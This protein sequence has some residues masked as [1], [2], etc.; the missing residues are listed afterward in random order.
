MGSFRVKLVSYFAVLAILP[1]CVAFYGFE[2]F[3]KRHEVQRVDNRL[4][5]DVRFALAAYTQQTDAAERRAQSM[6]IPSALT[7]IHWVLDP[8]D[9][10]VAVQNG[11]IVA[12]PY[13][14]TTLPL[15]PDN[16]SR[17]VLGGREYRG[18]ATPSV[19][20]SERAGAGIGFA[21]LAPG[22]EIDAAVASAR[23]RIAVG[24]LGAVLLLGA[25]TYLLGL[26]IVRSLRRLVDATDAIARGRFHE[27]V[28]VRGQDE[29]ARVAEAFNR[30]AAQL[31][32]RLDELAAERRRTGE[33]TTRFAEVLAAT[34]DGEQLLRVIVETAVEVTGAHGGVVTG[35]EGELA[36]A[37]DPDSGTQLLELPLQAGRRRF[38]VLVLSGESFEQDRRE[39]AVSLVSHAVVALENAR[40]HRIVERQALVDDL[41][42]LAN[43][44]AIHETLRSELARADRFNGELCL[45]FADLDNFKHV[46]D[47]HGHPFGDVVLR[48][49]AQTLTECVRDIDLAGRWGGE[50]FALVLPGTDAEGGAHVAERARELFAGR[51]IRT[52]EGERVSVSASFG[53]AS[54]P[55]SGDVEA[56]IAAADEALYRAKRAGKDCVST[57]T[58][59]VAR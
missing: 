18:F 2:T 58:G 25:L 56:L 22:H 4:R 35:P 44:R 52:P 14:G 42:G 21:A 50:E 26:S 20:W 32:Q 31:E 55:E 47:L 19:L 51:E 39:A 23:W 9:L 29:F 49:F 3:A 13:A 54:F 12:G 16:P 17:V 41:T 30:M 38:G 8:R 36:R 46:N 5:A 11:T 1:T 6:T 37:G 57:P 28:E 27:R 24:L 40:L 45:V 59:L 7:R 34:H 33:A 10:L 43:R 15:V 48:A 53:V